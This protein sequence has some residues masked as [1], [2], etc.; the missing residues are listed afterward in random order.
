MSFGI[1]VRNGL[2]VSIVTTATLTSGS[3]AGGGGRRDGGEP[4]L[5]LDFVGGNVPYGST[6]NLNFTGQ[7]Y[8]A[9]TADPA[10]QGFPNFWAWS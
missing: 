6:L 8:S 2:S 1:P 10:G 4:T 9:Y 7:T 5:I 3:G